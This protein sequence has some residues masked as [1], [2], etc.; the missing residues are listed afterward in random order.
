MLRLYGVE[1]A[2]STIIRE[3]SG[4]FESHSISVNPRH[5]TLVADWMTRAGGFAPF[6]RNG[7]SDKT[8]PFAKMSFETT[9]GFLRDA[10][11]EGGSDDLTSPSARIS[12]GKIN[13]VGT[14]MFDVL[15]PVA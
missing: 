13:R 12:V 14:G 9:F 4:V 2:R 6:N 5:L 7:F 3:L 8:S 10:V 1:A 11:C 15:T